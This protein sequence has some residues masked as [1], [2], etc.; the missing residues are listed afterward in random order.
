MKNFERPIKLRGHHLRG[1]KYYINMGKIGTPSYYGADFLRNQEE[2]YRNIVE[3]PKKKIQLVTSLDDLC[4]YC[5]A[6]QKD[7]L[8][9]G[10]R[11]MKEICANPTQ[12]QIEWDAMF[13]KSAN[14]EI[15]KIYDAELVLEGLKKES[16]EE[17]VEA[18]LWVEKA[19]DMVKDLTESGRLELAK[20]IL[21]K[22]LKKYDYHTFL[23]LVPY[24]FLYSKLKS[25]EEKELFFDDADLWKP[26]I[27]I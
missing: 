14:L 27:E 5:N 13:I 25:P 19:F 17:I 26:I 1:L 6:M 11:P 22:Y 18:S 8:G 16:F 4:E 12:Y 3:N 15:D 23:C 24:I 20:K 2:I 9:Q 21:N 10:D 7:V